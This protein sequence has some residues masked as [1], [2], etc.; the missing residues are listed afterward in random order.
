MIKLRYRKSKT[1]LYQQC[2]ILKPYILDNKQINKKTIPLQP[3]SNPPKT[4]SQSVFVD[5]P[6]FKVLKISLLCQT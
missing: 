1:L 5:N 6:Y 2:R 3:T 4:V